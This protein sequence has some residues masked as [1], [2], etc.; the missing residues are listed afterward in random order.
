[1]KHRQIIGVFKLAI[2]TIF[3]LVTQKVVNCL[4]V[5]IKLTTAKPMC[6]AGYV[7]NCNITL[8]KKKMIFQFFF[9][10]KRHF[11]KKKMQNQFVPVEPKPPLPRAV[12]P[13]NVGS[14]T[15]LNW[16]SIFLCNTTWAIL[17][18]ILTV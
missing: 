3:F 14:S 9:L 15:F 13:N 2:T 8:K 10:P 11:L 4:A 6:D 5:K 16:T 17:S 18:P 1:M 7:F 12:S